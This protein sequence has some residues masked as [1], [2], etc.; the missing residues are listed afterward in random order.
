MGYPTSQKMIEKL[1]LSAKRFKEDGKV[2]EVKIMYPI[3]K[4]QIARFS[5]MRRKRCPRKFVY[6]NII[7]AT[8]YVSEKNINMEDHG[9]ACYII[10]SKYY[11]EMNLNSWNLILE[12]VFYNLGGLYLGQ[13][14]YSNALYYLIK[15]LN[16][17]RT[18]DG[19]NSSIPAKTFRKVVKMIDR[20]K[21]AENVEEC[22]SVKDFIRKN[23]NSLKFKNYDV[24]TQDEIILNL[25]STD[26]KKKDKK[27]K[28]NL[29]GN[30]F[31]CN[32]D[33]INNF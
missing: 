20:A 26:K 6:L 19:E 3:I 7:A 33:P 31:N 9:M 32:F 22:E 18:F 30:T 25:S 16:N 15:A 5:I 2:I 17:S 21:E 12:F 28:E 11:A 29:I 8:N 23:L 14:Q 24:V 4:E 1:N 13:K 10:A 27:A